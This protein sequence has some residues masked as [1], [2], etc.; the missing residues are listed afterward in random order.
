[1][2]LT[3]D[4]MGSEVIITNLSEKN[5]LMFAEVTNIRDPENYNRVKCKPLT[6]DED[7]QETNW[8]YVCSFM[9]GNNSGAFF[10]PNVGDIV[11]MGYL[12]G[13]A[14]TPIVIG[15]VWVDKSKP[16]YTLKDGKNDVYSIK[17]KSGAELLIDET[18]GSEK[19][20]ITTKAGTTMK[21]D[22][23]QKSVD[24]KDKTGKNALTMNL[25]RG[26][27]TLKAASKLTLQAGAAA[28]I[29]LDGTKS[30]IS[31]DGKM[32][33]SLN[34]TR[35]KVDAAAE[36]SING[37]GALTAKSSGVTMV[38]GSIVKIN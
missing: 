8:A 12:G 36:C 3:D 29:V 11:L 21:L 27:I 13:N 25:S 6:L 31:A 23:G 5:D 14:H 28:T 24:I 18:S 1:M 19:I 35:I 26:E 4:F 20:S 32:A 15:R 17:T 10:H 7:T 38:K 30:E 33:V 22:D 16:P 37:G 2:G 34:A 9:S